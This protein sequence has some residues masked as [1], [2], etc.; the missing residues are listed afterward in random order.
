MQEQIDSLNIK[1]DALQGAVEQ[2]NSRVSDT[3]MELK[4]QLMAQAPIAVSIPEEALSPR[5]TY[6][7][8]AVH[9]P[10]KDVLVDD[11]YGDIDS[12]CSESTLSPEVQTQRLTAQLTAAYNRIAALEEQLLDCRING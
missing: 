5:A 7:K 11:A 2:L 9:Q 3:L 4:L 1:I 10:H 12:S 6:F 8:G